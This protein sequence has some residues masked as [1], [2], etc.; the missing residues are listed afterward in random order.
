MKSRFFLVVITVFNI[1][2]LA[3]SIGQSRAVVADG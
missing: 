1:L 2:L 3:L